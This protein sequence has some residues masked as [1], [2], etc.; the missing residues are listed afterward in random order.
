MSKIKY[1]IKQI[2]KVPLRY[3]YIKKEKYFIST[4]DIKGIMWSIDGDTRKEAKENILESLP[5]LVLDLFEYQESL[6]N[7]LKK[8][9]HI[10][11]KYF[12]I[13]EIRS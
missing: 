13:I 12:K 10:W 7:S 8:E 4:V 11:L 5:S 1:E 6:C 9:L 3:E 2:Q